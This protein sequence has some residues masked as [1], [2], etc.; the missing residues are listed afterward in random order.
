M[1][2]IGSGRPVRFPHGVGTLAEG[3]VADPGERSGV[4]ERHQPSV[5]GLVR[6]GVARACLR[7]DDGGSTGEVV[8]SRGRCSLQPLRADPGHGD[9]DHRSGQD[10]RERR[11]PGAPSRGPAE[12][13]HAE[14]GEQRAPTTEGNT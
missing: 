12:S 1:V 4:T 3:G 5:V 11:A 13:N 6:H 10:E 2:G 8:G 7:G 14:R 9:D